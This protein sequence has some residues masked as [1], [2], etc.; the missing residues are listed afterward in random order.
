VARRKQ[1]KELAP[2]TTT[3]EL[4]EQLAERVKEVL[5]EDN[6]S[7]FEVLAFVAADKLNEPSI[8]LKAAS[9]LARYYRPQVKAI[10]VETHATSDINITI[11]DFA[12]SKATPSLPAPGIEEEP[13][14][15]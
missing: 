6:F 13:E 8:R 12:S 7:P 14:D 1:L 4:A 2:S 3:V 10:A 11:S 15:E 9:E 5:G